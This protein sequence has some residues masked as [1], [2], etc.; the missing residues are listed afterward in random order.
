[1]IF[2]IVKEQEA[3]NHFLTIDKC[4]NSEINYQNLPINNPKPDILDINAYAKF[5][6]NPFINT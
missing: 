6:R 2:Q 4:H 1:M 5:E 3:Q